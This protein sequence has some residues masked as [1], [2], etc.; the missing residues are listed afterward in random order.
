MPVS[1]SA[2]ALPPFSGSDWTLLSSDLHFVYLD[3]VLSYHLVD[4]ADLL[5]GRPLLDFVHPDEQTSAKNDLGNVLTT[6]ALHGSVTRY[7]SFFFLVV[8]HA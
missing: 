1:I 8:N 6:K 5:I 7:A 2:D 3:P 4:Q